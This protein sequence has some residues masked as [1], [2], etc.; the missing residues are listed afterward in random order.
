[1][2]D[3][4]IIK[5]LECCKYEYDTKCELCCYNFYSRTGCRGELRRNAHALITR[6]QS[7]IER[8]EDILDK[9]VV[10]FAYDKKQEIKA[11]AYKEFAERLK[12]CIYRGGVLPTM[13]DE[14]I[15]EIDTLVKEMVGE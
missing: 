6:Q 2:K 12:K 14:F 13:E 15:I 5:A 9:K 8:L 1:M 11:E 3:K 7:E 4:D 10:E